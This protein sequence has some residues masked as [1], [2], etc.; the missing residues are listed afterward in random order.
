MA[1]GGRRAGKV[2]KAYANRTDLNRAV[3]VQ[4]PTG[5]PYGARKAQMD[6]QR[7]IPLAPPPAPPGPQAGG[8]AVPAGPAPGDLGSLTRATERPSEPLTAGLASGPGPGPEALDPPDGS[9][10]DLVPMRA[11]LPTLEL[12]ANQPGSSVAVRNFVRRIRGAMPTDAP[13]SN[14]GEA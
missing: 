9:D 1:R 5:Q 3:P 4:A 12:L 11:Y 8:A 14:F 13:P 10:P 2:G 7:A 6:A